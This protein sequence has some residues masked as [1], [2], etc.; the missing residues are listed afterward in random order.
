MV[1]SPQSNDSLIALETIQG[2]KSEITLADG[3]KVWLNESS[4]LTY[5]D[6]FGNERIV[7]LKGEAFFDVA[8]DATRPFI[9]E[10]NKSDITV[11]G[12]SF[13][14]RSYEEEAETTVAV[15]TGKVRFQPNKSAQKWELTANER[16]SYDY[17]N[18][19]FN[20]EDADTPNEW[21][22]HSGQLAFK[23]TKLK[24]VITTMEKQYGVK[25]QLS[26]TEL[27]ECR[28]YSGAFDNGD[29]EEIIE[30]LRLAI[31]F[32]LKQTSETNYVFYG[33][34]CPDDVQ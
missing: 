18:Q 8:K 20:K 4:Q 26:N 12:T 24:E 11:L 27:Y 5:P 2:E 13:N 29:V 25:I 31:N 19:R 33:G 21:T 32:R 23:N 15:R 3:T 17:A 6:H 14:V 30:A 7:Q 34:V 16:I 22:W 1:Q 10:T 9:I 28:H